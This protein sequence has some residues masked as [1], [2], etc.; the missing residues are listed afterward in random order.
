MARPCPACQGY[1][2]VLVHESRPDRIK[3]DPTTTSPC[4]NDI[5]L[6][7]ENVRLQSELESAKFAIKQLE[8]KGNELQSEKSSLVTVIRFLQEHNQPHSNYS[9]KNNDQ[10]DNPW[11][12]VKKANSKKKKTKRATNKNLPDV[13]RNIITKE[14]SSQSPAGAVSEELN[15]TSG[16]NDNTQKEIDK[17]NNTKTTEP[18]KVIIAGNSMIKKLNGF[19]MSTKETRVKLQHSLGP[20]L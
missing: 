18:T 14:N 12:V 8:R 3:D 15:K 1:V 9:D 20:L 4:N 17:N 7:R 13:S 2:G 19:I 10:E 6:R 16:N 5:L 11:A